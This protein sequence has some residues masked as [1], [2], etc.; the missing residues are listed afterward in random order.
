MLYFAYGSNM[1]TARLRARVRSAHAVRPARLT[2]HSLR[3]HKRSDMDGSGKGDA[4]FT[5]NPDDVVWGVIFELDDCE[6]PLLD[7][8]EGLGFG[9]NERE[10][11]VT[12]VEG[13]QQRLVM[14]VAAA[15]HINPELGPYTWY[16]S[17][18][19]EGAR[20]HSLPADYVAVI[21]AMPADDDRDRERD[22]LNR[23]ILSGPLTDP[24]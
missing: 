2:N 3:F 14:Y 10:V 20:Q 21:D 23:A 24:A 12:D 4:Y 11:T 19:V 13:N 9:Y 18:V 22:S 7:R 5:G 6:K 17:F 16:K 1:H 15:T 8:H